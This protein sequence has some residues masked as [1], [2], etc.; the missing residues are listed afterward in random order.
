MATKVKVLKRPVI[1]TPQQQKTVF[2][3]IDN[4]GGSHPAKLRS[5]SDLESEENHVHVEILKWSKYE[6]ENHGVFNPVALIAEDGT[7]LESG[8]LIK[9][10]EEN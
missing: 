3:M 4:H 7:L 6:L 10:E 2:L 9:M 8:P 1:L 5:V